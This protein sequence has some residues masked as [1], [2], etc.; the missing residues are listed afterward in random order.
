M[1]IGRG[2]DGFGYHFDASAA[3]AQLALPAAGLA[4]SSARHRQERPDQSG[5]GNTGSG[6]IGNNIGKYQ[7]RQ[8]NTGVRQHAAAQHWRRENPGPSATGDGNIGLRNTVAGIIGFGITSASPDGFRRLQPGAPIG[9]ELSHWHVG[10]FNPAAETS[11]SGIRAPGTAASGPTP[12]A[13]SAGS[14]NTSLNGAASG[15]LE[16]PWSLRA[17]HAT[18]GV[19][20]GGSSSHLRLP[21]DHG[22]SPTRPANV[23]NSGL[24]TPVAASASAPVGGLTRQP[25]PG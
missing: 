24:T 25:K 5:L 16:W 11:A 10:L 15:W 13:G 1:G 7:H 3:V 6:N 21:S 2:G 20:H 17:G 8:R 12:R 9:L 14:L 19:E 23:L 4:G 22:R 18:G